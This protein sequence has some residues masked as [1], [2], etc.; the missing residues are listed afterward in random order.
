MNENEI[1][2]LANFLKNSCDDTPDES[3]VGCDC[4][5]CAAKALINAGYC[6]VAD[7][8]IVVKKSEYE[9][10]K[11]HIEDL[12]TKLGAVML[13]IKN[14]HEIDIS[15]LLEKQKRA[16]AREILQALFPKEDMSTDTTLD[17]DKNGKWIKHEI[18]YFTIYEDE[19]KDLAK[20]YG[21]ELEDKNND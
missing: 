14:T 4:E 5:E 16:T 9:E 13:C 10:L 17:L 12:Q 6:R 8:K 7:D 11:T 15:D 20:A 1:K 19:V 3:C 2:D 18:N 21:I